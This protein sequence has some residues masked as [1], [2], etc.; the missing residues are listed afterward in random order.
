MRTSIRS[1]LKLSI[2]QFKLFLREPLA[3]FFTIIFPVALLLLFGAI[4]GNEPGSAG[5]G[6]PHG[7]IDSE[8]PA[9][10]GLIIATIALMSLPIATA[11]AREHKLLRRYRATPLSPA[12]YL[13]ADVTVYF[14]I[15]L[16][17]LALLVLT[18]KL[19]F[20]MHV[21]GNKL[22]I[23]AGFLLSTLSFIAGGYLIASLAPSER[24]AQIIGQFIYFPMMF[25]SG[26]TMPLAILPKNIR[27]VSE[28][29]PLTHVVRLLQ[30][31][32]YGEGWDMTAV[33]VLLALLVIGTILSTRFFRW[34]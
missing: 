3:F 14:F 20:D 31:L 25:L 15:A 32:W 21:A 18:G 30:N 13:A 2:I 22:S 16:A 17:G 4:W 9:L 5:P 6:N 34:E 27:Q 12:I 1:F 24:S 28:W 26:A 19:V 11:A 10:T 33:I 23:V 7:Y 29:L 8:V